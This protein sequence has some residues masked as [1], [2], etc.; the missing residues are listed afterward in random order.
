MKLHNCHHTAFTPCF[1]GSSQLG[2]CAIQ[3]VG[4]DDS[5]VRTS[6]THV[7]IPSD[8]DLAMVIHA[9]VKPQL[10]YFH[11][12]YVGLSLRITQKL[13]LVQDTAAYSPLMGVRRYAHVTPCS[14]RV[15]LASR[16]FP[17]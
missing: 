12:F 6:K 1:T 15:A 13:Q 17:S 8:K 9:L 7:L 4:L 2:H 16:G 5:S 11:V 3:D 10:D 14:N